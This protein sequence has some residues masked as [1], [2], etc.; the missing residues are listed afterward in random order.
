MGKYEPLRDFLMKVNQ[1]SVPMTFQEIES[2]L[3]ASLPQSARK[4][5]A[6][7]SNNSF[8]STMTEAWLEAGFRS[9][10]VDI[11]EERVIFKKADDTDVSGP[12]VHAEASVFGC[13]KG[14]V[15]I[16]KDVDLTEPTGEI[17]S[18]QSGCL[19]E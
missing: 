19:H 6:W 15:H 4:H 8:N 16:N 1:S 7:W 11:L 2:L 9:E 10:K 17:W 5:R 18:A 3:G 13:L 12:E 14:T